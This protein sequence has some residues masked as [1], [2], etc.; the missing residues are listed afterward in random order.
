MARRGPRRHQGQDGDGAAR[1]ATAD[2]RTAEPRGPPVTAMDGGGA[3]QMSAPAPPKDETA[4][5]GAYME[6]V[7][8][9]ALAP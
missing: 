5:R 7:R 9:A 8:V 3:A 4:L 1:T 2:A 6:D